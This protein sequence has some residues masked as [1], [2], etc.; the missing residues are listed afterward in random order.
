[1]K[2]FKEMR[3][4]IGMSQKDLAR[5]LGLKEGSGTRLIRK[6]ENGTAT[7]NGMLTKCFQ[8]FYELELIKNK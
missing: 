2:N 3:N 4:E 1:M 8:Y 7:P 5:A 6:I